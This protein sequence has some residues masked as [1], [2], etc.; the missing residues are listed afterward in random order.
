MLPHPK[1]TIRAAL[2]LS[3][4][5]LERQGWPRR[6]ISPAQLLAAAQT[7]DLHFAPDQE[8][9]AHPIDNWLAFMRRL[10]TLSTVPASHAPPRITADTMGW[11]GLLVIA[12][13]PKD[14]RDTLINVVPEAT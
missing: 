9:P 11:V 8:V 10:R 4:L 14:R 13:V 1:E 7:L 2:V 6:G 12:G 5:Q 3:F